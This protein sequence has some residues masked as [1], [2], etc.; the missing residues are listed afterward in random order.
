MPFYIWHVIDVI[1]QVV[2]WIIFIDVILSYVRVS[3]DN[4][5]VALVRRISRAITSPIRKIIQPMRV[6]DAYADFSP[7]IA[8]LIISVLRMILRN[9]VV[10]G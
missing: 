3:E 1:L 7:L 9:L 5:L 4:P 8:I 6:G 2:A 10:R